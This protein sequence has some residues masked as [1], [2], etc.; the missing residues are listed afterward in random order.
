[1]QTVAHE[2]HPGLHELLVRWEERTGCPVLLNTSLNSRGEP[3][4]DNAEDA[5]RFA[6]REGVPVH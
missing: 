3:L 6:R 1:V 2:E 5:A 4:V